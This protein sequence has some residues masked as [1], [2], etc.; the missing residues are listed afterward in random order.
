MK[1]ITLENDFHNLKWGDNVLLECEFC[2][3]NFSAKK[4][5]VQWAKKRKKQNAL[6]YCNNECKTNSFKRKIKIECKNCNIM[7]EKTPSKIK[8]TKN[9]F[10]S[11]SCAAS[12][13]NT[14]KTTGYRRSKLEM[15]LEQQLVLLYP[16]LKIDFNKIDTINSELDIYI[17]SLNLAFELNGIFHYE[18]IYSEE[19]LKKTQNNDTRKFQACIEKQIELCVIDTSSQSYF[20][21]KTSKKFLDIIVDIINK[22]LIM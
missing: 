1:L 14:H 20:K 4:H 7:F 22:K 8:K 10:C 18:P 19:K 6:C 16:H 3:N 9:S 15:W 17:P 21:E 12:Y 11:S 2:K 13:N 5:D